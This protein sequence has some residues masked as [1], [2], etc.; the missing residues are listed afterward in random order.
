MEYLTIFLISMTGS[1]HCIGMCG[2]FV[3]IKSLSPN[4][5]V[6]PKALTLPW[7]AVYNFGRLFTYVFLGA[8]VGFLGYKLKE[9]AP[10]SHAQQILAI[11]SGILMVVIGLQ[12][13]G[14]LR[15]FSSPGPDSFL[16]P[17][18][19]IMG[20]F[21]RSRDLYSALLL[22]IFTGFL[23]CSLVYAFSAKAASTGSA[24]GGMRVMLAFGLGTFPAMFF[25]G[26]SGLFLRPI[27]RHRLVRVSATLIVLLGIITVLRAGMAS[28]DHMNGMH[29]PMTSVNRSSVA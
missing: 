2:G 27:L 19:R 29:H 25:M 14:L 18:Y 16:S 8:L 15:F 1:L 10:F 7:H 17:L 3:T 4:I 22:G 23:P 21:Q 24:L 20:S 13:L 11:A 9:I 26:T 28:H 12:T 6:A 5:I